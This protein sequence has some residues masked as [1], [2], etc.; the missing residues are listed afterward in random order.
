MSS[1]R[2][3]DTVI[4][5]GGKGTRLR[6]AVADLPKVMAPVHGRPFLEYLIEAVRAHGGSRIILALGVMHQKVEEFVKARAWGKVEV[7]CVVEPEARGTGGA[8]AEAAGRVAT[9]PVLVMNGD[10]FTRVDL[11]ALADFHRDRQAEFSMVA[12]RVSDVGRYG[13]IQTDDRD[14]IVGT[15]EKPEGGGEGYV[16][17]GIYVIDRAV[18]DRI[19]RGREV[20]LER[21]IL[22]TLMRAYAWKGRFPFI[23]IGTPDSYAAAPAFFAR[24]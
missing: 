2:G 14:R 8:L 12:T 1:L 16:N 24:V 23:D 10:S 19:P 9:D 18:I 6:L 13:W 21:E 22:P 4:L 5:A 3:I 11:G 15:R 7:V 17:A 20:S